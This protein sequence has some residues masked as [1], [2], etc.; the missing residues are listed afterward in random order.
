MIAGLLLLAAPLYAADGSRPV[1]DAANVYRVKPEAEA[2]E[3]D[4]PSKWKFDGAAAL[5]C[6]FC[7]VF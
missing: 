2:G 3:N 7:S 4:A 6:Y 1:I 5:C